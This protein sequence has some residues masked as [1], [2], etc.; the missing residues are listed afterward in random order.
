MELVC[1]LI[2]YVFIITP[3]L[4]NEIIKQQSKNCNFLF[5]HLIDLI[6]PTIT[7][8]RAAIKS[9][10]IHIVR[11]LLTVVPLTPG[12][13]LYLSELVVGCNN[14]EM[15]KLFLNRNNM[16]QLLRDAIAYNADVV[17]DYLLDYGAS[18]D[19]NEDNERLMQ[20]SER[21]ELIKILHHHELMTPDRILDYA[22]N[23]TFN[24]FVENIK[25]LYQLGLLEDMVEGL[26]KL[27]TDENSEHVANF[28]RSVAT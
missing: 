13:H 6:K 4:L 17:F 2:D 24:D 28:L 16:N 22:E 3:Q 10:N 15:L 19:E 8:L 20:E 25:M 26:L 23:S 7:H 18:Y 14:V 1:E 11:K 27:A 5:D 21:P 9:N 12:Q